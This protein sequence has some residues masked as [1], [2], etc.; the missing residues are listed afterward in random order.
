MKCLGLL[1][2]V[3]LNNKNNTLAWACPLIVNPDWCNPNSSLCSK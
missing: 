3:A 1:I 2:S